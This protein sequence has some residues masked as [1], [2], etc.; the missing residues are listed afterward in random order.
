MSTGYNLKPDWVSGKDM[1]VCNLNQKFENLL[2]KV[3]PSGIF[4]AFRFLA[5]TIMA[6]GC[7]SD[8]AI[9]RGISSGLC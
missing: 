8:E 6:S 2:A 9:K 4:L 1:D 3:L 7:C 5:P